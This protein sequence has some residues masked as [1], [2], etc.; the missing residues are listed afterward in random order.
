MAVD[1]KPKA[2]STIQ[3]KPKVQQP[4]SSVM[5]TVAQPESRGFFENILKRPVERLV[6]EPARRAGEA[7]GL[8]IAKLAGA[9]PEQMQRGIESTQKDKTIA[10]FT[11]RGQKPLGE[12]GVKQIAGETLETGSWLYG[13]GKVPQIVGNT[14]KGQILRSV[15]PSVKAATVGMGAYGAGEVLQ[16]DGTVGEAAKQG[17][18]QGAYGIPVGLAFGVGAPLVGK[19]L[20]AGYKAVTTP[21]TQRIQQDIVTQF[22][23]GVKPN[24]PGKTTPTTSTKFNNQVAEGVQVINNNKAGLQFVDEAGEVVTGRTPETLKEF[25]EAIEQ[26]K[27]RIYAEYDNLATRAG[28]SGVKVDTLPIANELSEV[29]NNKALQLSNPEAVAYAK[30]VQNRYRITGALDAKTAQEVIQNYNNALQAFYRNPTPEG[31]TRNAVD[32]MMVNRIRQ[33]LDQGIEG[34]TGAQYQ[35]L[36]NQYGALKAIERDVMRATLRDA[37]KNMKGLID[38]TDIFSGGQV[39]NGLLSMNPGMVASGMTQKAIASYFKFLNSPSRAIQKMFKSAD[40]LP[41]PQPTIPLSTRKQ[42]PAPKAGTP[43]VQVDVPINLGATTATARDILERGNPNIKKPNTSPRRNV[44]TEFP[45]KPYTQYPQSNQVPANTRLATNPTTNANTKNVIPARKEK[46]VVMPSSIKNQSAS[47]P[48]STTRKVLDAILPGDTP[49]KEGGFVINPFN[50]KKINAI[51]EATK[52][53]IRSLQKYLKDGGYNRTMENM[54]E[55]IGQKY[56]IPLNKG[57]AD[58]LKYINKLLENTKTMDVLPATKK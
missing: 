11:L 49:N 2:T 8:G 34:M 47:S 44:E 1:F 14:L 6:M 41:Q 51:D 25:S 22:E 45:R 7:V 29:I 53:E 26:T 33:A 54:L 31:L 48:K 40:K 46:S 9:T 4:V 36:K 52:A 57:K 28:E 20:Q 43:N 21:Q 15:I 58:Q 42:L 19:G 37:R 10:G 35:A 18:I 17:V 24:L 30:A 23:K 56:G 55:N 32:A 27:N 38:Y 13:G 50:K 3:F 5:P 16:Q 12:G 39:V